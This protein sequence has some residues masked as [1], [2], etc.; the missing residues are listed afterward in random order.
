LNEMLASMTLVSGID[1]PVSTL[2]LGTAFYRLDTKEHWFDLLDAFLRLGGTA[3]DTARQYGESEAV[4]GEWLQSRGVREEMVVITK[5]GH[6]DGKLPADDL[7][8]M[9]REELEASLA[10]LRTDCVDVYMLHRDNQS[11]PVAEIMDRLNIEIDSRRVRA[12]GAS[13]WEYPRVDEANEY[14][15]ERGTTGFA[16]VSNNL[17][18]AVPTA[19][20]FPG[21]VSADDAGERWHGETGIPLMPWSA[22][23]RGF[24][25]GQY[26][27]ELRDRAGGIED[28]FTRRMI[29]VYGTDENFERLRRARELGRKK[30]GYSATQVA[31]AW[32]LHKAFP[33]APIVGPRTRQELE[34]CLEATSLKLTDEELK[35]LN[36]VD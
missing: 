3:I 29:E 6:R 21:L 22:Q 25:T 36:L 2:V 18:L 26:T 32:L 16:V 20:F 5:C 15:G 9:V 31:L 35:W 24:F 33:L 23:A 17:S 4:V 7:S 19:P 30:G 10:S 14:A 8:A 1:K 27:P 28:G 13:N 11:I 12:L 34:S